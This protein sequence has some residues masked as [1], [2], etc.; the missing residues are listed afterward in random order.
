ML[1]GTM[2]VTLFFWPAIALSLVVAIAGPI[3][4][5]T[6]P[7]LVAALLVLPASAYLALTPRFEV[8]GLT[9]VGVYLLAGLAIRWLEGLPG[10][11]TS[12]SLIAANAWFF[13]DLSAEIFRFP[14][15]P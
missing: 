3:L 15:Y 4:R 5:K 8:W 13:W 11:T 6:M 7:L 9:P 12:I 1:I 10:R 14:L 2:I